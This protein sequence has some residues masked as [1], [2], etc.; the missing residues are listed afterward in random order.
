MEGKVL[1]NAFDAVP[2]FER[3][4]SWEDIPDSA[5]D[6]RV[7]DTVEDDPEAAAAAL[8]QLVE[9]GYLEAPSEDLQRDIARVRAEQKYNLACTFIDGKQPARA[10]ILAEE[11]ARQ[12]PDQVRYVVFAGQ[13]AVSAGDAAVPRS[14]DG[15]A[16]TPETGTQAD[17][18]LSSLSVLAH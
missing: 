8:Q 2:E 15:S 4:A 7:S 16:G 11:L 13:A 6:S 1:V 10:L 5:F 3:I 9:L 17:V 12:F 18:A 14:R